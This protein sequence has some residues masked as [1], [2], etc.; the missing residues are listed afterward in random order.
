MKSATQ[1]IFVNVY[2]VDFKPGKN[3]VY[4]SATHKGKSLKDAKKV[5]KNLSIK[6]AMDNAFSVQLQDFS[7]VEKWG[8]GQKV[9]EK[10]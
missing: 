1:R 9:K 10:I 8:A 3:D 5:C 4:V 2:F 6:S 7:A